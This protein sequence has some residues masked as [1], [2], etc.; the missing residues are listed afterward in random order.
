MNANIFPNKIK[1]LNA[2]RGLKQADLCRMTGISTALM[3]RYITE[4]TSPSLENAVAIADALNVT[5]DT[6]VGRVNKSDSTDE[7]ERKI[8]REYR[9]LNELNRRQISN[10]ISAFLVQQAAV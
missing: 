8:L 6:L 1:E 4:K 5:L 2:L 10:M 7:D 3:S 9:E